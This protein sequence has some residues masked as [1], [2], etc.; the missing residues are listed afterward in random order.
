MFGKKKNKPIRV[1]HY[2]GLVDFAQD[3]PCTI[4]MKDDV[5]EIN[6]IKPQATV[7]LPKNQIISFEALE[8][9]RFM[10]KYHNNAARTDK[11]FQKFYLVVKYV[12]K[13]NEEK[14]IA[15][16]GTTFEYGRFLDLQKGNQQA[17]SY[18]L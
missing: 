3:Y 2:E 12:S 17:N 11:G 9:P 6:K 18:A 10:A 4:E 13:D 7:T 14:Y 1:M 16:W 15:F 5:F 8:E